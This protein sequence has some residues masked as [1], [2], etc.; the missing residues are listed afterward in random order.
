MSDKTQ[1]AEQIY[2]NLLPKERSEVDARELEID[3]TR[4]DEKEKAGVAKAKEILSDSVAY[5]MNQE[6]SLFNAYGATMPVGIRSAPKYGTAL[7]FGAGVYEYTL[8]ILPMFERNA[9][10]FIE[11]VTTG[12]KVANVAGLL[13]GSVGSLITG[14]LLAAGGA[15]MVGAGLQHLTKATRYGH[16]S[17]NVNKLVNKLDTYRRNP[18]L[19]KLTSQILPKRTVN[20][21]RRTTGGQLATSAGQ[22]TTETYI[23]AHLFDMDYTTSALW[24][25]GG[26]TAVQAIRGLLKNIPRNPAIQ[27][28]FASHKYQ[29]LE[30][31]GLLS[32]G[33]DDSINAIIEQ[34]TKTA[35]SI[36]R[37]GRDALAKVLRGDDESVKQANRL[38]LE[39]FGTAI[40]KKGA[41]KQIDKLGRI[42]NEVDKR[43]KEIINETDAGLAKLVA[44]ANKKSVVQKGISAVDA[45]DLNK[46]L[47]NHYRQFLTNLRSSVQKLGDTNTTRKS[48]FFSPQDAVVLQPKGTALI[49]NQ[50][51]ADRY[52]K[53]IKKRLDE[54]SLEHL[55]GLD[56][57]V[58]EQEFVSIINE[59]KRVSNVRKLKQARSQTGFDP[60]KEGTINKLRKITGDVRLTGAKTPATKFDIVGVNNMVDNIL[61]SASLQ[62]QK[63]NLYLPA[64]ASRKEV[65]AMHKRLIK[66]AEKQSAKF[67]NDPKLLAQAKEIDDIMKQLDELSER[68]VLAENPVVTQFAESLRSIKNL[69]LANKFLNNH[70]N[71]TVGIRGVIDD[72]QPLTA[73]PATINPELP[74]KIE[75]MNDY[76]SAL[77]FGGSELNA[78][79]RTVASSAKEHT[80]NI[81]KHTP[82]LRELTQGHVRNNLEAL[83]QGSASTDK[84]ILV[85]RKEL[86][87]I[88][89]IPE[90]AQAAA[91]DQLVARLTNEI[92]V[93]DPT[94]RRALLGKDYVSHELH[95]MAEIINSANRPNKIIKLMNQADMTS[96][97]NASN[98]AEQTLI[99]KGKPQ[100]KVQ[101][102][103][104]VPTQK[105]A[106]IKRQ[107][108]MVE[109]TKADLANT[110][111]IGTSNSAIIQGIKKVINSLRSST[112][113]VQQTAYGGAIKVVNSSET[114]SR[115]FQQSVA[116]GG[117]LDATILPMRTI[118]KSLPK[119]QKILANDTIIRIEKLADDI[120]RANPKASYE[121]LINLIEPQVNKI[122]A[123]LPDDVQKFVKEHKKYYDTMWDEVITPA[124]KEIEASVRAGE[125]VNTAGNV[126]K[127]RDANFNLPKR[128]PY[129]YPHMRIG[130]LKVSYISSNNTMVTIGYAKTTEEAEKII[131]KVLTT[132]KVPRALRGTDRELSAG[133]ISVLEIDGSLGTIDNE[134][135]EIGAA[136][137][138]EVGLGSVAVKELREAIR[139][140]KKNFIANKFKV[141]N[142][143]LKNR[144]DK[145]RSI[146]TNVMDVA[147]TY[148]VKQ[149]RYKHYA[150]LALDY[151]TE[152]AKL[153]HYGME[154]TAGKELANF[155]ETKAGEL[156]GRPYKAEKE[157]DAILGVIEKGIREIPGVNRMFSSANYQPGSRKLRSLVTT[158]LA[159]SRIST[160]GLNILSALVQTTMLPLSVLPAFG[161][162][163]VAK[164]AKTMFAHLT[165]RTSDELTKALDEIG[166]YI[167]IADEGKSIASIGARDLTAGVE[168]ISGGQ[169]RTIFNLV[170][171]YALYLFNKGDRFPRRIAASMAYQT[172]DDVLNNLVKKL[173]DKGKTIQSITKDEIYNIYK[174]R[175]V[176]GQQLGLNT[177]E[178]RMLILLKDY[179]SLTKFKDGA[180]NPLRMFNKTVSANGKQYKYKITDDNFRKNFAIEVANDTN[181]I[182]STMENPALLNHPLLK[183]ATQF[184]VFTTKYFERLYGTSVRNRKEF[185]E[186]MTILGLMA[187]PLAIPGAREM[188]AIADIFT[189]G[190]SATANAQDFMYNTLGKFGYAGV[191]GMIGYDFSSRAQVGTVQSLLFDGVFKQPQLTGI[192]AD[193]A[194]ESI[195][196]FTKAYKGDA[197]DSSFIHQIYPVLPQAIK[198][199]VDVADYAKYGETYSYN[200]QVGG[201][202]YTGK[203]IDQLGAT[204]EFGNFVNFALGLKTTTQGRLDQIVRNAREKNKLLRDGERATKA[205]ILS[206][207]NSG[208]IEAARD[209]AASL[210]LSQAEL[211]RLIRNQGR[212]R[213]QIRGFDK[214]IKNYIKE[215]ARELN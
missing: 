15:R 111:D 95:H 215:E 57:H 133:R 9:L 1:V 61:E 191:P 63:F 88:S 49:I 46:T 154:G 23:A 141:T 136:L 214:T 104:S 14:N 32:K 150:K 123:T 78:L 127:I 56:K 103:T 132:N 37:P 87:Q 50:Q 153:R 71:L 31:V 192:F 12:E 55:D 161:V 144:S 10:S 122:T 194:I 171:D 91:K 6:G 204:T 94:F 17:K 59:L 100:P 73:K 5:S 72:L 129:Y 43:I 107:Q 76:V 166:P 30:D 193:G 180:K 151:N 90:N 47:Q 64:N 158:S 116:R 126:I 206:L 79:Q 159:L 80:A 69:V 173:A 137:F 198:N 179:K 139:G 44:Q 33:G 134:L 38:S 89:T 62:K 174:L 172:G 92:L 182:Y 115:M 109:T 199:L 169:V 208:N 52:I 51:N 58:L 143:N 54:S 96:A 207:Y 175:N 36:A 201:I 178:Y 203:E 147:L 21:L 197:I 20:Q 157:I 149:L 98:T 168:G 189:Q 83:L 68:G 209:L 140:G 135:P 60:T 24:T 26:H 102:K 113:L 184:K 110:T 190:D 163:N 40:E 138:N 167:G 130:D 114:L 196:R 19:A 41:A 25:I 177:A 128:I 8:G 106:D 202:K 165:R 187:G 152:I 65:V 131:T 188:L 124:Q 34:T 93:D 117:F 86:E 39:D 18:I 48:G 11:P 101:E 82:R 85:A 176:V 170:E 211:R 13:T 53:A 81:I 28:E 42:F 142:S 200:T 27:G 4:L 155:L 205:K 112:R 181:F 118:Y 210:G 120:S 156:F 74:K 108:D 185:A 105:E 121:D 75:R 183:P 213:K 164:I 66:F 2:N 148:G 195:S 119:E 45:P 7:N 99:S 162:R 67:D 186:M 35:K 29:I 70:G 97:R 22:L 3:E 145:L 160:L 212:L 146:D 16:A 84:R 77:S 125:Q